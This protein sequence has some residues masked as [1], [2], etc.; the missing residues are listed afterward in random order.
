MASLELIVCAQVRKLVVSAFL[1]KLLRTKVD[2]RQK[3]SLG[4]AN[5]NQLKKKSKAKRLSQRSEEYCANWL[6]FWT[7]FPC[8]QGQVQCPEYSGG[9]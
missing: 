6:M 2:F 7:L 4:M 8:P 1:G 5:Q 9:Q 3:L